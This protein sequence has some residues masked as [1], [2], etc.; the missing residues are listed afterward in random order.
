MSLKNNRIMAKK[1]LTKVNEA[2][3]ANIL[4]LLD[5]LDSIFDGATPKKIDR[6]R[7]LKK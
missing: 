4:K 1:K 6:M 7:D 2:Q 3:A 5:V